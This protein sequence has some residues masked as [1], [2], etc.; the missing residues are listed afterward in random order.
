L[1]IV[2]AFTA[3]GFSAS[4]R[5]AR[6]GERSLVRAAFVIVLLATT[7]GQR[8]GLNFGSYSLNAALPATYALLA[9]AMLSGVLL[10]SQTR[11]CAYAACVCLGALATAI[12]GARASVPSLMLLVVMYLPFV[13]ALAANAFAADDLAFARRA[14]GLV[15]LGC[16]LA[17]I[18]QFYAQFV[19]SADW[20]FDFTPYLPDWLRGPSGYNTVISVGSLHKS[21]G[22]FFHEPSDFSFVMALGIL[23]EW[24]GQKRWWR[25]AC[26]GLA[27]LLTYSGTGIL[28]LAVGFLFPLGPKTLFRASLLALAAGG[29]FL[30]LGDALN[31]SFTLGRLGEFDSERSSAYIRY[32]APVRLVH[33][34]FDAS[35]LTAWFGHGPGTITSAKPGYEFHDPTW[36]KLLYEYGVV[37]A[38]AVV[39]LYVLGLRRAE[40]PIELRAA[41]LFSWLVTSGYLL[42]PEHNYISFAFVTLLPLPRSSATAPSLADESA[43]PTVTP[44]PEAS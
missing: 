35:S 39:A 9:V 33:D 43:W 36:A 25:L 12:N 20:L 29:V 6:S 18:A 17:G 21:N 34:S 2:T 7:V 28:T 1:A 38:V 44:L 41:L 32:I 3:S 16:A 15:T 31:L 42:S 40:I 26:Y 24:T 10:V 27:L 14:F 30:L 13:F 19:I 23:F 11:L 22:F 5:H 4:V 8:F 37:G